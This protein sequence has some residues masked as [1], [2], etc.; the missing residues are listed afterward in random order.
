MTPERWLKL[1][2]TLNLR[3]P[4]LTVVMDK[5]HK[6]H[7]FSAI[8]RSCDAVG[9]GRVHHVPAACGL[10]TSSG[11][12]AGSNKWVETVEHESFDQAAARLKA[13]G[14]VLAAAHASAQSMDFRDYDFTRPT[15]IVLGTELYGMSDDA[16]AKCD[17]Q[18]Q[19]P[20]MG[21]VESLNV[22]VACAILLYEAQRQRQAAGLYEERRLPD[23]T[24]HRLLFEWA[25]PRV[26]RWCRQHG[27]PYPPLR[28]D[29][30]VDG[31]L[32]QPPDGG[33]RE[34]SQT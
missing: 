7:N 5:V 27:L 14:F 3:Q 33:D 1:Q 4:D 9:V 17:V 30:E 26:A 6:M 31:P 8:V 32:P 21:M 10:T 18:L 19:V 29:G 23:A 13:E 15:A 16:L 2:K 25:H 34:S 22:S 11:L 12:S 28:E 24:Y 20:M